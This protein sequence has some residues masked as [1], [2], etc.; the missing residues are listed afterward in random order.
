MEILGKHTVPRAASAVRDGR[1]EVQ[2][3]AEVFTA[4]TDVLYD[5]GVLTSEA[6]TNAYLH[7]TGGIDVTVSRTIRGIR[8]EVRDHGCEHDQADRRD[9]GRGL[10]AIRVL[11]TRW[12]MEMG[13]HETRLWFEVAL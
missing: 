13:P 6:V 12:G 3:I 8:V 1:R 4:D 5:L 11:S 9:N 2:R 10:T 7:G